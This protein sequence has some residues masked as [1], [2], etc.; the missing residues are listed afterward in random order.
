MPAPHAIPDYHDAVELSAQVGYNRYYRLG[1][2]TGGAEIAARVGGPV[3][4]FLGAEAWTV[5]R[6]LPP[7][8]ALET[9][10]Y[11]VWDVVVPV[12][13]GLRATLGDG[14]VRP[15][16]GLDVLGAD[17]THDASRHYYAFGAR[18]RGGAKVLLA[19]HLAARATLALGG[20]SGSQ[21]PMVADGAREAG[22]LAQISTGLALGF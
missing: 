18:A 22:V 13:G 5:R 19:E 20:W 16:I 4:V 17:Y 2:V 1:F 11:N 8:L 7:S 3:Q 6:V 15:E 12:Y 14:R 10:L 21:W 9:G